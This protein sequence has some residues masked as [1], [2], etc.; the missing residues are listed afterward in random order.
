MNDFVSSLKNDLTDRRLVPFVGLAVA[1]LVAA[2]AYLVL[3]GGSGK[4]LPASS[5]PPAAASASASPQGIGVT[6]A[7][8]TAE[9]NVAETTDG[10]HDQRHGNVRNPFTALPSPATTEETTGSSSSTSSSSSSSGSGSGGSSSGGS[11]SSSG[12]SS[13]EP[14][15]TS[16]KSKATIKIFHVTVL[17]GS[18]EPNPLTG[19]V[20]LTPHVNLKLFTPLPSSKLSLI[21]YRGVALNGAEAGQAA[22]FSVVGEAILSGEGKCLPSPVSCLALEIKPGQKEKIEYLPE[23]ASTAVAYELRMVAIKTSKT[24]ITDAEK[25]G[26]IGTS[27]AGEAA[28]HKAH[29]LSLPGLRDVN[30]LAGVFAPAPHSASSARAHSSAKRARR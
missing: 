5:V 6:A 1:A 18:A 21:V 17:F 27:A 4:A 30:G 7:D 10:V 8:D 26:S 19:E 16:A 14:L 25:A 9:K 12:G 20:E 15:K 2:L 28:L 24:T 23:G 3:G 11:G 22:V 13:E 29:R